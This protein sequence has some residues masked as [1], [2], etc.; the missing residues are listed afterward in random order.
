MNIGID[1]GFGFVKATD[2]QKQVIFPSVVGE[3]RN[4]R[5]NTGINNSN[6]MDNLILQLE[7]NN[8]FVGDLANRQSDI[9]MSTLSQN[10]INSIEH[11]VLFCTALG[12]LNPTIEGVNIVTGLP[13]N[14][15]SDEMK[16]KLSQHIKGTHVFKLNNKPYLYNI[17]NC[18]VIPQPFGTIFDQ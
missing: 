12:L 1:I 5:Y 4:I 9:V 16:E 8:Y 13:V 7:G 2:G 15:Y 18:K 10:R 11:E 17:K 6:I 14:E 3:G